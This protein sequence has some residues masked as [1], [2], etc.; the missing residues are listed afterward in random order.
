MTIPTGII[1]AYASNTYSPAGGYLLCNGGT[2]SKTIYSN[3]F[4]VIGYT[5]GGSGDNFLVPDLRDCRPLMTSSNGAIPSGG[6]PGGSNNVTLT[7]N[8]LVSHNHTISQCSLSSHTH[9][10]SSINPIAINW[11]DVN[12][13]GSDVDGVRNVVLGSNMKNTKGSVINITGDTGNPTGTSGEAFSVV[14]PFIN[15]YYY[16]KF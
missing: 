3:L 8:N 5:Y 7:S 16:I 11:R 14:N 1:I 4:D 15:M 10:V 6:G 9:T 2:Y 12:R 13:T